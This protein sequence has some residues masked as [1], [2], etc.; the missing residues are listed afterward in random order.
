MNKANALGQARV[1]RKVDFDFGENSPA[2]GITADQFAV[3]WE[4]AVIADDTGY[5]EFRIRTENGARLYL[6]RDQID[7][8]HKLRDDSSVAGQA[9]LIDAWVSSG[10][11]QEHTARVFLLGGRR[12]P[13]RL[14]FFKYLEKTASIKLEWKPPHGT[15]SVLDERNLSSAKV[16]RVF[17][18][19]TPFPADDRSLGYE[20]GS[21]VSHEWLNATTDAAVATANEVVERLPLLAD[22]KEND[23]QYMDR[24]QQ[25]LLHFARVAFRRP[26]TSEEDQLLSELPFADWSEPEDAVRRAIVFVLT[27]PHFL[28]TDLPSAANV[29]S[30]YAIASRLSYALWDSMPDQPLLNAARDGQLATKPRIQSQARRMLADPRARNKMRGFFHHWLEIGERDLAKDKTMFPEFD[31]AVIADLRCSLE[32]FLDQVVWSEDSDY[33]QLL[34][35]DHLVLNERLRRLYQPQPLRVCDEANDG[36]GNDAA[37]DVQPA[38]QFRDIVFAPQRRAGVLTHP[39]LLTAFAYHNNTSPIHRGVFL[40]RNIVGRELKP[41]PIAVAFKDAEFSPDLTMRDKITQL[42]RD[43]ACM[44]CHSII[45]PLGFAMENFDAVGRWR[46]SENNKPVDTKSEYTTVDGRTLEIQSARDIA[47]YAASSEP[48]QRA[49]VTQLFQYS[50]KQPPAAYGPELVDQLRAEFA[51]DDFNIRNLLARIAVRSAVHAYSPP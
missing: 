43:Q 29:P 45:N 41:P 5:Y 37:E 10:K 7:D 38:S 15:W 40:T 9:A 1:D 35:A 30:Q 33:R 3:I 16:A 21:S 17:V 44:S 22:V 26:L 18:V 14:E 46:T 2:E 28:Y 51:D 39:Y 23:P 42:T 19:S 27:S 34:L 48:A 13:L 6:N 20:R 24:T 8:R 4:G 25:F 12:Y 36:S 47:S 11:K 50:I 32:L 31:E 49:F